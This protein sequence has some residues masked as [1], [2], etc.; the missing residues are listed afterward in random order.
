MADR[1]AW[2]EANVELSADL[3]A[4]YRSITTHLHSLEL[5]AQLI[6]GDLGG[7]VMFDTD[8]IPVVI[9]FSPYVR[10]PR[11]AT[12]I[13]VGDALLREGAGPEVLDLLGLDDIGFQL[14]LRALVFRLVAEQLADRPRHERDP[15]PYRQVLDARDSLTT[16]TPRR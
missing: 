2:G 9:D 16:P 15:R 3:L 5:A 12:A 6:H 8:D 11:Y 10:P 13:V 14:L 4:V 1:A 7:N